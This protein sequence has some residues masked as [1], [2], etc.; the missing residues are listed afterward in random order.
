MPCAAC[1]TTCSG[2]HTAIPI[3]ARGV[4][5]GVLGGETTFG[6]LNG[7]DGSQG[8]TYF[9]RDRLCSIR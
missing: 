8:Y 1:V 7:V 9:V 6:Y 5:R 2:A 4:Y 3:T